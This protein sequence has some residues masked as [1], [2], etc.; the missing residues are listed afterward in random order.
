M[1]MFFSVL[2]IISFLLPAAHAK[3]KDPNDPNIMVPAKWNA[4][5]TL[6]KNK[7]IDQQTR[8]KKID[9]TISPIF[10]FPL[11]AKLALGKK[12][13]SRFNK[14]QREKYSELFIDRLKDLYLEKIKLYTDEKAS[15]KKAVKKTKSLEIPMEL[16][17]KEKKIAILYKLRKVKNRW[18]IYDVEIEGVSILLTYRSQ[19]NDILRRNSIEEF[20]ASLKKPKKDESKSP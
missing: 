8:G 17:S 14:D 10:D 3:E 15:F 6:I 19:F 12:H 7:D 1:R 18:K 9:K 11:M 20:L 2:V 13:W 4:V 16:L 5:V